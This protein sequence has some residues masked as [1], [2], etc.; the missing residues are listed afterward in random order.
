MNKHL[1]RFLNGLANTAG[2]AV[3]MLCILLLIVGAAWLIQTFLYVAIGV[4]V[5]A[6]LLLIYASGYDW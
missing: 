3:F 4:G 5:V 6:L 2:F 1:G